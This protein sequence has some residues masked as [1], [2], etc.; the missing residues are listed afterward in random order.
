MPETF[1]QLE[2]AL[3]SLASGFPNLILYLAVVTVIFVVGLFVYVKLTPHKEIQLIRDNN[4]A[5][6]I[7]FG[8]VIVGLALP[9]AACLVHKVSIVDVAVWGAVSLLLQLFLFRI[10]D[11]ILTGMPERIA[12][13]EVPAATVLVAFKFAGSLVLA[14]AIAG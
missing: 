12:E 1:D 2:P 6:A 13:G 11:I 10:T 3:E 4:L 8:G 5:A 9:L 7:S 14:F